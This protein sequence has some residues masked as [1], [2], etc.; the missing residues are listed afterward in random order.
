[1][2]GREQLKVVSVTADPNGTNHIRYQRTFDGLRVVGGDF[3]VHLDSAGVIRDVSWNLD[4]KVVVTST[5]PTITLHEAMA[6]AE[7]PAA[8]SGELVVYVGGA[9]PALA[10]D[11][12]AEGVGANQTPFRIHTIVDARVGVAM[13]SWNDIQTATGPSAGLT[14]QRSQQ[15]A[16]RS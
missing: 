14:A 1:L 11:V 15:E 10:Y 3:V 4:G 9:G 7:G 6:A 2:D 13:A 16:G 12:V 8:Q 5:T